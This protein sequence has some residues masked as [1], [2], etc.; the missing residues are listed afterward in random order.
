MGIKDLFLKL[1]GRQAPKESAG[2]RLGQHG[3]KTSKSRIVTV[4]NQKGGC[5]KTTTAI[6][7]SACLAEMGYRV[8]LVDLDPQAHASLNLGVDTHKLR[9]SIYHV[10]SRPDVPLHE[11]IHDTYSENLKIAPSNSFLSSALVDLVNRVGREEILKNRLGPARAGFDYI[12]I[13]CPPSLNILTINALA[14]SD[15]L[16]IPVQVQYFSLE[17]M[18]DLFITVDLVK[19]TLNPGLSIMGIVPTLFDKRT[20]LSRI[21]LDALKDYFKG[22]LLNTVISLSSTLAEAPIYRKPIILYCPNSKGAH[23]YR[24]LAEEITQNER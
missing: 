3:K 14:A 11:I 21:M 22:Q 10:L 1:Y 16:L 9:K 4:M 23:D 2:E 13:D 12:F 17:G 5:G 24:S 19:S 15:G 18:N 8:L 20:K 6:N 7:L